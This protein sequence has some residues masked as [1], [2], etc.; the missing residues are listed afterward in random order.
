MSEFASDTTWKAVQ[1]QLETL[2]QVLADNNEVE[3]LRRMAE[4]LNVTVGYF[5]VFFYGSDDI[6]LCFYKSL[7]DIYGNYK[8]KP[9]DMEPV[10][11]LTRMITLVELYAEKE[12]IDGSTVKKIL[13]ANQEQIP[14]CCT[15]MLKDFCELQDAYRQIR[16]DRK[17]V[18]IH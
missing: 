17:N 12:L 1:A 15:T 7:M 4:R 3:S 5:L 11:E 14:Y 10:N 18:G 13:N 6:N 9:V 2:R 8:V 16:K